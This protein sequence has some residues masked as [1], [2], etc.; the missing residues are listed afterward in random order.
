MK[1]RF[2]IYK[3]ISDLV[4]MVWLFVIMRPRQR[5]LRWGLE[6]DLI[7]YEEGNINR[8]RDF[9]RVRN[10]DDDIEMIDFRRHKRPIYEMNIAID[11]LSNGQVQVT[12]EYGEEAF[13]GWEL[14]S[15][16]NWVGKCP[17]VMLIN[18]FE[19]DEK[20]DKDR[21]EAVAASMMILKRDSS[22]SKP[23]IIT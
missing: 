22:K 9:R 20:G 19:I 14:F 12:P 17:P 15:K 10:Q 5:D 11:R 13:D 1:A 6:V 21:A 3:D 18:T 23:L 2:S 4:F 16:R 7:Q 8:V